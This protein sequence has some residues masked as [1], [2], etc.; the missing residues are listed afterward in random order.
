MKY[1]A[2][3]RTSTSDQN[4]GLD[5]QRNLVLAHLAKNDD[6]QLLKEF[7]EQ[8]TGTNKRHRP[9]LAEA[10][11]LCKQ[12]NATLIIAKLDR[13]SRNVAFISALMDSKVEFKALDLPDATNLTIHIFAAIAQ[14]E[15]DLISQRTRAALQQLKKQGVKLGN[16]QNLNQE[17]REQGA[18]ANRIKAEENPNNKKAKALVKPYLEKIQNKEISLRQMA[19]LLNKDGFN[20]STGRKFHATTVQRIVK[21]LKAPGISDATN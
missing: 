2:Y 3:Y 9:K 7:Q 15:A 17:A 5:A 10:I 4:L 13:L 11:E 16:P 21:S 20:T 6:I 8:E 12:K 1:I 14:H 19:D 18:N